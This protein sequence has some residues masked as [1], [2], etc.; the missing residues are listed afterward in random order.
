M[1]R[2][3]FLVVALFALSPSQSS[4]ATLPGEAAAVH[5]IGKSPIPEVHGALWIGL[6]LTDEHVFGNTQNHKGHSTWSVTHDISYDRLLRDLRAQVYFAPPQSQQ[7]PSAAFAAALVATGS[8]GAASLISN[9]GRSR[10]GRRAKFPYTS[11]TYLRRSVAWS[12][13]R[14]LA[15]PYACHRRATPVTRQIRP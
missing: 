1:R 6:N 9:S 11:W 4:A 14:H 7:T 3:I 13:S 2:L 5:L 10:R 12:R 15:V 8:I